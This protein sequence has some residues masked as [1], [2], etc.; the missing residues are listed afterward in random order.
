MGLGTTV[1]QRSRELDLREFV[2]FVCGHPVIGSA[3]L[4]G[5]T[6]VIGGVAAKN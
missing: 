3:V 6:K 4:Y 1:V 5:G 2:C